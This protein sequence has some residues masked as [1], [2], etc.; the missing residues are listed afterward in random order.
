MQS[1][2]PSATAHGD[3]QIIS[4]GEDFEPSDEWKERSKRQADAVCAKRKAAAKRQLE[5]DIRDRSPQDRDRI[6]AEH[7]MT[8]KGI[9]FDAAHEFA[10]RLEQ[11]RHQRRKEM[12][13]LNENKRVWIALPSRTSLGWSDLPWPTIEPPSAP[14]DITMT[15]IEC[16]LLFEYNYTDKFQS[17]KDLMK[18]YIRRWHPDRF[19]TRFL[20]KVVEEEKD[21][22]KAGAGLVVRSLNELLARVHAREQDDNAEDIK[23]RYELLKERQLM[24]KEE[25]KRKEKVERDREERE[26]REGKEREER[27]RFK[28]AAEIGREGREAERKRERAQEERKSR[29]EQQK[30]GEEQ[31]KGYHTAP[32]PG[33]SSSSSPHVRVPWGTTPSRTPTS[34]RSTNPASSAPSPNQ[35]GPGSMRSIPDP[36]DWKSK[37]D[38]FTRQHQK[39]KQEQQ[40]AQR[41]AWA[42]KAP[43]RTP[44]HSRREMAKLFFE[45]ERTW[46]GLPS[47]TLLGW[48]D[49][50]W[51]M[52]KHPF[53]PEDITTAA[54]E[55]Y[56][57]SQY[58]P[59]N[60]RS[61]KDRVKDYVKRWHPDKFETRLL[62]KVV[63][64]EKDMVRDGAGSVVR[65]L[66]ELLA[67]M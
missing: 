47:R 23:R 28:D 27:E 65:S 50:P 10:S 46:V 61:E 17:E 29:E 53:S 5:E 8:L 38:E 16:Y 24:E 33:H 67:R 54:I 49:F 4:R 37:M 59:D 6:A 62:V 44:I 43:G 57:F 32:Y 45:N 56:I 48:S 26:E 39:F 36:M 1:P 58:H 7:Q 35:R 11:E 18:H 13:L 15:A 25:R 12:E 14:G 22:V 30:R 52:V 51:P 66:N 60:S 20:T 63:E 31:R 64:E 34:A 55:E 40:N 42:S 3:R 2:V 41:A 9:H 19:E 21:C